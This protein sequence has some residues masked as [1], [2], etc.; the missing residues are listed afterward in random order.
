MSGGI[1]WHKV[2]AKYNYIVK[3]EDSIGRNAFVSSE[4]ATVPDN[5]LSELPSDFDKSRVRIIV[6]V[7][8]KDYSDSNRVK[9]IATNGESF[10]GLYF[11][12]TVSFNILS[13]P[14]PA[15][16]RTASLPPKF[17]NLFKQDL[18]GSLGK[19]IL[20]SERCFWPEDVHRFFCLAS[21][22]DPKGAPRPWKHPSLI[23]NY[24]AMAKLFS[25]VI[26]TQHPL[27]KQLEK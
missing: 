17:S 1:L 18:R 27:S 4:Y 24:Y 6:V 11:V 8:R 13:S 21:E 3:R 23:I 16:I 7:K 19:V 15:L 5:E 9:L 14:Q 12:L 26:L 25:L 10:V 20:N 22:T 2:S